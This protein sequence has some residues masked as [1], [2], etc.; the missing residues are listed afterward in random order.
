MAGNKK[1]KTKRRV[2][3][4]PQIERQ[5]D[6]W[7]QLMSLKALTQEL[8]TIHEAQALQLKIWG[9]LALPHCHDVE[10][11]VQ[12]PHLKEEAGTDGKV[13]DFLIDT[14]KVEFRALANDKP[15]KDLP[16]MLAGLARSVHTMLGSYF[17]VGVR[18]N[19]VPIFIKKGSAKPK[20]DMTKL[21]TRLR[22]V[23]GTDQ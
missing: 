23:D 4:H 11:H 8:G 7:K 16:K 2:A 20:M 13:S 19:R 17:D 22:G 6:I 5:N 10:I 15:P 12:L 14:N 3:E 21:I 18:I 9:S 1:P